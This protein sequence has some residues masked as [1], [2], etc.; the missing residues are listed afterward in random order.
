[1]YTQVLILDHDPFGLF[2]R[3]GNKQWL[4]MVTAW[5]LQLLKQV[6]LFSIGCH[7]QALRRANIQAGITFDT[8][9]IKKHRLDITVQTALNLLLTCSAVKPSSTS[10]VRSLKRCDNSTCSILRRAAGS[11]SLE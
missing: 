8:Q 6:E 1:M 4:V 5:R 9:I 7:C 2:Q 10:V 3:F 11:K